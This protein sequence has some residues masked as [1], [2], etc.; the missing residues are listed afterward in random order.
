MNKGQ[1]MYRSL[2]SDI[3]S[4][5]Y[6]PNSRLPSYIELEKIYNVS[7]TTVNSCIKLLNKNKIIDVKMKS[8]MFVSERPPFF[9]RF[10]FLF[11]NQDNNFIKTFIQILR[12]ESLNSKYEFEIFPNF[13]AHSDNKDYQK[14]LSGLK[15]MCFAGMTHVAVPPLPL[16]LMNFP[17]VHVIDATDYFELDSNF[18]R[19]SCEYLVSRGRK[20]IALFFHSK[21][22]GIK[23]N[24]DNFIR[25][26]DELGMKSPVH[27]CIPI[28]VESKHS[29]VNITELLM[30]YPAGMRPD[31]LVIA[32]DN[33]VEY[34]LR[35]IFNSNIKVPEELEI[36]AHCNWPNP[37]TSIIPLK[38]LGYDVRVLVHGLVGTMIDSIGKSG[39]QKF[40]NKICLSSVFEEERQDK[41]DYS[42][43][44][45][46]NPLFSFQQ[47]SRV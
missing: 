26:R 22:A 30:N 9:N 1:A 10:A 19:K 11:A 39:L 2:C 29:L 12:E 16:E 8:G 3:I 40:N 44:Q 37:I 20:R 35:G 25:I 28:L 4:G 32:D 17:G 43:R 14:L 5:K 27:W 45:T 6:A 34:V 46:I 15:E 24:V 7:F 38:R 18:I 21:E 31:G 13:E 47:I 42:I 23:T 41:Q 33:F 36:V